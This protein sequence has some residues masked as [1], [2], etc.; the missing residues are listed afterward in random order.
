M[1]PLILLLFAVASL[2]A[3]SDDG[4]E[5]SATP[6]AT[7]TVTVPGENVTVTATPEPL[8]SSPNASLGQTQPVDFGT[9]TPVELDRKI[10]I[11]A[12]TL[13]AFGDEQWAAVRVKTCVDAAWDGEPI[14]LGWGAWTVEDTMGAVFSAVDGSGA[15]D[16]PEPIYP[17]FGDRTARPGTC[18]T[19]WITFGLSGSATLTNVVYESSASLEPTVWAVK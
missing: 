1:R 13:R 2:S 17:Q 10:D 4:N 11:D 19:G 7:V 6:S 8:E 9:V 16:F 18:V 14:K 5:T 3:C 12:E 15:I